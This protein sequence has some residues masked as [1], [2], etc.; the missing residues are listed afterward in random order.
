M[1]NL[2]FNFWDNLFAIIGIVMSSIVAFWIYKLSKQLSV[3]NLKVL[4]GIKI[5]NLRLEKLITF[6]KILIIKKIQIQ[7][8]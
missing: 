4:N 7:V 2:V 6:I 5:L 3:V 1:I 8:L